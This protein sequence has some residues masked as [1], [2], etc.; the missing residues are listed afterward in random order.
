MK[1]FS[2][3]LFILGLVIVIIVLVGG[4][5]RLLLINNL[6]AFVFNNETNILLLGRPGRTQ[7]QVD[8]NTDAIMLL[9]LNADQA[10]ASLIRIPRDLIVEI[11]GQP[12]KINSLLQRQRQTELLAEVS[13][14][15]GL[16]VRRYFAF[17][18]TL[19]RQ[20]VDAIGGVDITLTQPVTDAISG[21]TLSA[22]RHHLN[23]EWAE[24]VIR[25]RYAPEGDFFRINT[26]TALI[27]AIQQ[28]LATLPT[29]ELT[30]LFRLLQ[31][32]T[33][34]YETNFQAYELLDFWTK[35]ETIKSYR[36]N[37]IVIGTH[38][39]LLQNG[40]F[41]ITV[42]GGTTESAGLI[43]TAGLGHYRQIRQFI[44]QQLNAPITQ[45]FAKKNQT[46]QE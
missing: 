27:Q 20:L 22:G 10:S 23:G 30:K 35:L 7:Y 31:A 24:F 37:N 45:K 12:Y 28:K 4:E 8:L 5:R 17:D 33:K 44:Q 18:L 15:T 34:H 13:R 16:P 2:R 3:F 26:Q 1:W 42:S 39:G 9:H 6:S 36:L 19:V 29:T 14:L 25:S 46:S 32:N 40:Y 43:P 11:D 21:Y 38:N 41:P